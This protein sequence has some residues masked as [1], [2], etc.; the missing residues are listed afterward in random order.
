MS[1]INHKQWNLASYVGAG[2]ELAASNFKQ[3]TVKLDPATLTDGQ[4]ILKN[5]YLS[6]DA[7]LKYVTKL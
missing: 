4:V 5:L 7:S 3:V 6:V 1:V 2:K